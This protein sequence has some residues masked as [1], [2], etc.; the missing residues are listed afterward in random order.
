[1]SKRKNLTRKRRTRSRKSLRR[2]PR[3]IY[4][5]GGDKI[6]FILTT[7]I[8][9]LN[10]PVRKEQYKKGINSVLSY[11]KNMKNCRIIIVENNGK[12]PTYLDDFGVD[13]LYTKN[14]SLGNEKGT[15]ELLDILDCIKAFNIGDDEF[16]VKMTGRYYLDTSSPFMDELVNLD[17]STACIIHY[18]SYLKSDDINDCI[19]GLIGMR[20]KYIQ[21]ITRGVNPIEHSW[22]KTSHEIPSSKVRVLKTLGIYV[23]PGSNDY[24]LV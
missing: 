16:V 14:N 7:C 5:G 8:N 12:R 9:D 20:S 23:C 13:V 22:A 21:K 15:T 17:A 19:T 4:K 1:M 2:L 3:R 24:I 10:D 11:I 18:G 6:N